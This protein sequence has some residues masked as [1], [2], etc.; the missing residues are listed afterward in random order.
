MQNEVN[1]LAELL[2]FAATRARSG[3]MTLGEVNSLRDAVLE[4]SDVMASVQ[5]LAE[6]YGQSEHNVR[7]V[8]NRK[9]ISKPVRK[10]YY[11]FNKFSKIVPKSWK[12]RK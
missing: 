4:N 9:M 7:C 12:S 5:E 10:V 3:Q 6:H 8:I 11:S 1:E 2:D